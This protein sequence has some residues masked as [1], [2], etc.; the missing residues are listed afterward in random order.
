M[1]LLHHHVLLNKKRL[2]ILNGRIIETNNDKNILCVNEYMSR[3]LEGE[4]NYNC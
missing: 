3:G 4:V 1:L 2:I